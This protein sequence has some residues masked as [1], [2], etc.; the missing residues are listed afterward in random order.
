MSRPARPRLPTTLAALALLAA[1]CATEPEPVSPPPPPGPPRPPPPAPVAQVEVS[2]GTG[3]LYVG[4]TLALEV[5]LRDA[6]GNELSG[7]SIS[8]T[9][10]QES[11]ATVT[12]G[13]VVTGVGRGRAGLRAES[14]GVSGTATV[15][16]GYR[17]IDV[18]TGEGFTCVRDEGLAAFCWGRNDFGQVGTGSTEVSVLEPARVGALDF[19]SLSAYGTG[20]VA[21]GVS[22]GDAYCWGTG[23]FGQQPDGSHSDNRGQHQTIARTPLQ[24]TAPTAIGQVAIGE[25]HGCGMTG[26]G[27]ALCWGVNAKGELNTAAGGA[28]PSMPVNTPVPVASVSVGWLLSCGLVADGRA[29]CWGS[30]G[31]GQMGT[32]AVGPDYGFAVTEAAGG[33]RFTELGVGDL[34][35]CGLTSDQRLYC[36]GFGLLGQLGIGTTDD[37]SAPRPVPGTWQSVAVGPYRTCAVAAD[38]A[39][40]CWGDG[41][42]GDG[43]ASRLHTTPTRVGDGL[44]FVRMAAGLTQSCGVTPAGEL[45]CWG[46]NFDG[47]LGDG[48]REERRSPVRLEWPR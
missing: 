11:V 30:N 44:E 4:E 24:I 31:Y 17:L 32:G 2:S 25:H 33:M 16:S 34:H 9:S 14:E 21:C 35:T 28:H 41:L 15:A 42:A 47:E 36:W 38:G 27:Q 13:G 8:F 29:F 40:W 7:R 46:D 37:E 10:D 18:A 6:S 1:A 26:A 39:G 45:Y 43:E 22:E 3:R 19:E 12:S 20:R 48:T 5:T 23:Y